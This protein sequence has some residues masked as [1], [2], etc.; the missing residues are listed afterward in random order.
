M[1]DREL[2]SDEVAGAL[3]LADGSEVAYASV[4]G[5]VRPTNEDAVLVDVDTSAD[6]P[7]LVCVADGVGGEEAGEVASRR[8]VE[9]VVASMRGGRGALRSRVRGALRMA[10]VAVIDAQHHEGARMATTL[11]CAAVVGRDVVIGHVG[12]SRAF[13]VSPN[14]VHQLTQDHS[15]AAELLRAG[16][17]THEEAA[18]HPARS[19]LT[20]CLGG[21]ISVAPD[22][23]STTLAPD[24][25]LLLCSD[26]LWGVVGRAAMSAAIGRVQSAGSLEQVVWELVELAYARGAP[27][28]VSVIVAVPSPNAPGGTVGPRLAWWRRSG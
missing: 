10:N 15:Q 20:R 2:A 22:L 26:G 24:E 8:A 21:G 6:V 16:F 3:T 1:V 7:L 27:D 28:N 17:I 19:V 18:N 9:A 12:D 23:V 11:T 14:A 25:A 13:R 4:R 5:V